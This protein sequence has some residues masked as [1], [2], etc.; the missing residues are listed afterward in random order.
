VE[1]MRAAGGDA[2][3]VSAPGRGTCVRLVWPGG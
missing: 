1:R 3:V 2:A